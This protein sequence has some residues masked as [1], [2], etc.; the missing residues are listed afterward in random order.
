M[1]V[2]AQ[3]LETSREIG[4]AIVDVDHKDRTSSVKLRAELAAIT[5]TIR[6]RILY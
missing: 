3:Y 1:N 4:Y 5:G 6:T 2:S